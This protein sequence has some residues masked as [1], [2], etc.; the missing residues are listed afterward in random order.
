MDSQRVENTAKVWLTKYAISDMTKTQ[1]SKAQRLAKQR[2]TQLW[3]L[4]SPK[5]AKALLCG[6]VPAAV[7]RQIQRLVDSKVTP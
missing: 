5:E 3:I 2:Q 4:I 1:A 7:H 6:G